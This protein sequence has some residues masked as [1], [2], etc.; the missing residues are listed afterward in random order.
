LAVEASD[1]LHLALAQRP[2]RSRAGV[3]RFRAGVG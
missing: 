1:I 3:R 2:T